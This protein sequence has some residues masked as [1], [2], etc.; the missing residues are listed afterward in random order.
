M[1][2][3][4]D[5]IRIALRAYTGADA[6]LKKWQ[7]TADYL[8]ENIPKHQFILIPF[9]NNGA[10][11]QAVSQGKFDFI[12]TNPAA[13]IGHQQRYGAKT[14]ATLV[15]K[16]QGKGYSKFGSVIFARADRKDVNTLNDLKGKMFMGADELGFGGWRVAWK[17]LLLND[18]DPYRDFKELRFAGGIQ[19]KVVMTVL[20]GGVAAGSV[21][22]DML[23]RMAEKGEIKLEDFK[24][25]GARH[26]RGFPFL[27]STQLYPEWPFSAA[28]MADAELVR[29]VSKVLLSIEENHPA[30][31][32][33][34]YVGWTE[35]LDYMPVQ[36]L[37]EELRVGPFHAS[38]H[39]HDPLVAF[40]DR[41]WKGL[42]AI[43]F[44]SL[45]F[46]LV[47]IYTINLNRRLKRV[48][49]DLEYEVDNRARAEGALS[50]LAQQSL[51][52]CK[53]ESFFHDCVAQLAKYFGA[54]YAFI[55]LFANSEKTGIKTYA[56]WMGDQFGENFEYSLYGTPCQDVLDLRE[57]LI[58]CDAASR[59]PDDEMLAQMGIDSYFGAPLISPDGLMLGLVSVMD[60]KPMNPEH[61]ARQVLKVFANRIALEMQRKREEEELE[62]L[63][64]QLTYQ[65]SHDALTGLI[66]RR[67]FEIRMKKAWMTTQ[68]DDAYH[69]F[70]YL[71][72]DQFK[73][74]ND[75]CGHVAGDELLKQLGLRLSSV[76]RENDTLARLGG[77]EFG[78]L[79]LDCRIRRAEEIA[80]K[81][82]ETIKDFRFAWHDKVF[83]IGAS[84]GLVPIQKD[85]VSVRELLQAADSA[86]YVAKEKGRNRIHT[87]E[88]DDEAVARHQGEMHWVTE[89]QR[90]LHG[91]DIILYRQKIQPLNNDAND[92]GF[93]E[94]LVRIRSESGEILLPGQFIGA[95][96]R[97][98][99]MYE[100]DQCVI[101]KSF[102]FIHSQ[103]EGE[104]GSSSESVLYSINISGL[105]LGDERLSN[106]IESMIK[107]F[108]ISPQW[109]CFEITET[110]AITNYSH[111]R[112]FVDRM[113]RLGFSFALDDF[114]TG[115]CSYT[116][117]KNLPVN[118]LK[119]D[120]NFVCE[121]LNDPMNTAIVESIVHIAKAMDLKT[122]A[123]WVEDDE[124]CDE[125]KRIGVNY[126]QG[127]HIGLPHLFY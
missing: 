33:G 68:K 124:V 90:A 97:Y 23:E 27:H 69:A 85:S 5:D 84:I 32:N 59:Y 78:I 52:F 10:L 63:T 2:V 102:S 18:I 35:P 114:G 79:L 119:I 99:I 60:T 86:C 106:F 120:G 95:A 116:Y 50:T 40:I 25:L 70:C 61:G 29:R 34:S 73:V 4:A 71:D 17:E 111:A 46:F 55:G 101:E 125:L 11:N 105:S 83:E 43:F 51:E 118:Y 123:E 21:R 1:P 77:D 6:A 91:G 74:I 42:A 48:Q 62:G 89:I 47:F 76:V 45:M 9:E 87:Y 8:T 28:R 54:E 41:Y 103:C 80:K 22:T 15:N 104:I 94:V 56:L 93:Y 57:E 3:Y 30:A 14:I 44:V 110:A 127:Y 122:I 39:S 12:L 112:V 16:R 109:V 81:L 88:R 24:V 67:E 72:L 126:V 66:N 7:P 108:N 115:V 53:E 65:A 13:A 64:S 96:E 117:L 100:L 49:D 38:S 113:R 121:L 20:N 26:T 82:L 19:Q 107:K 58:S 75:T 92:Q 31:I 98:S 36:K 37:L